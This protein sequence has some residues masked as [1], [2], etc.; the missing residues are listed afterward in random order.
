MP[1]GLLT[2]MYFQGTWG[3]ELQ[4]LSR[5][6]VLGMPAGLPTLRHFQGTW[7]LQCPEGCQP[8][9]TFKA[10]GA[11]NAQ[12]AANPQVLSRHLVLGLP[13]RRMKAL[14]AWNALR[15]PTRRYFQGI[16]CLECPAGCQPAGTFKAFGAENAL[17]AANPQVLSRHLVLGMPCGL[18]TRRY[19]QGIWCLECPAGCQPAG[20][21]KAF[22]TWNALREALYFQDIWRLEYPAGYQPAGYSQGIW[23]LECPAGCHSGGTFKASGAWNALRAANAQ[24]FSRGIW[25]LECSCVGTF[26][27]SGAW[28]ALR[29]ANAQVLSRH[30]K[31]FGALNAL[32]A[33]NPQN[34][35]RHLSEY[36]NDESFWGVLTIS[37]RLRIGTQKRTRILTTA[38][39]VLGMPAAGCQPAGTFKAFGAW[40]A[41]QAA[42]PQVLSKHLV[43]GMPCGLRH[44][45][46]G[47]PCGLSIR[48]YFQSI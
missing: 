24:V 30:F 40:N 14:G 22:G 25:C 18:L 2:R 8:A 20:I 7:C 19:F 1:C 34:F 35:S 41:L 15:L 3:L 4:V 26:K 39:L 44:F 47:M 10:F 43:L 37:C 28:N 27:A 21:F 31:A 33:A 45:V 36:Q 48:R 42:N 23:C 29:A 5:H 9:G 46:L 11:W 12:P 6:L 13:I 17:R 16:W 38:H 32:R